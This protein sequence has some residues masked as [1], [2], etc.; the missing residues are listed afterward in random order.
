MNFDA[1]RAALRAAAKVAFGVAI[2]GCGGSTER[3]A[4]ESTEPEATSGNESYDASQAD[5]RGGR[6]RSDKN[7]KPLAQCDAGRPAP[8]SCSTIADTTAKEACCEGLLATAFPNGNFQARVTD[9]SAEVSACCQVIAEKV[10]RQSQNQGWAEDAGT[11]TWPRTQCCSI[12]GWPGSLACTPWGPPTPPPSNWRAR[13]ISR[14]PAEVA[15]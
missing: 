10:D 7:P 12:L 2:L 6:R 9:A 1:H 4:D 15:A 5:L 14:A 8:S 11:F 13:A 3:A